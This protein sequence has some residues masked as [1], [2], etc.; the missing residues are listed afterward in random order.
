MT[1]S[2]MILPLHSVPGVVM[3]LFRNIHRKLG[4]ICRFLVMLIIDF[5]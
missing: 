2:K 3:S 5:I 1:K 4:I